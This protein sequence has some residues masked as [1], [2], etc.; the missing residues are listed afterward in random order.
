MMPA[1][2]RGLQNRY[3]LQRGRDDNVCQWI[4]DSCLRGPAV[5]SA[6]LAD[7]AS[8][9]EITGRSIQFYILLTTDAAH[10]GASPAAGTA[11]MPAINGAESGTITLGSGIYDVM[12]EALRACSGASSNPVRVTAGSADNDFPWNKYACIMQGANN[13]VGGNEVMRLLNTD[14]VMPAAGFGVATYGFAPCDGAPKNDGFSVRQDILQPSATLQPDL[15]ETNA[16]CG[17]TLSLGGSAIT[18]TGL[19]SLPSSVVRWI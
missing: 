13:A 16:G 18:L 10:G 4:D 3:S 17:M 5:A 14:P 1:I 2:V 19:D 15:Q 9:A 7:T 8:L 6:S 12:F 11:N